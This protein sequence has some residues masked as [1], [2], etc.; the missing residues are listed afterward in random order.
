[1]GVIS[2]DDRR[3]ERDLEVELEGD[4][5]EHERD[6]ERR[7][8]RDVKVIVEAAGIIE[9][10]RTDAE[11]QR[12]EHGA[13]AAG[14]RRPQVRDGDVG[15]VVEGGSAGERV[16]RDSSS[17][18]SARSEMGTTSAARCPRASASAT[19]RSRGTRGHG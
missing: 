4:L 16:R 7:A 11:S 12:N 5:L 18:S 6:L 13:P 1:M 10:R 15:A 9:Y 2:I 19:R 8:N 3:L 17:V 14:D